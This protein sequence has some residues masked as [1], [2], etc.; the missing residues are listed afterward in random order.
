MLTGS[1]PMYQT[2]G[3][4]NTL[5][6]MQSAVSANP[7]DFTVKL[8]LGAALEEVGRL[9]EALGPDTIQASLKITPTG[10]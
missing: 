1:H 7:A 2:V 8:R 3:M 10:P 9:Q 6:A 4:H 5:T